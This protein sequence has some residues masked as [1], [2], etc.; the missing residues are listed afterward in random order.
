MQSSLASSPFTALTLK[1]VGLIMIVSSLLDFVILAIPFEPLKRE[2][3]LGFTTQIVDRGIIPMVGIALVVAG[4][5]ISNSIS[6]SG[7]EPK[8]AVQDLRFWVFLLSSLLGLIFLL[9]VPLHI[10]NVSQQSTD[11]QKQIDQKASQ[12]EA[13]LDAQKKNVDLI[14]KD[15]QK[16]SE[17]EKAIGSGQVQGEQLARLQALRE[18]LQ[19]FK[20][21]PKAL[22]QQSEAA[23]SQIRSSKQEAQKRATTE[24]FK[25][26]LR[27]GLSSLLLAIGYA[28][29]GWTGFAGGLGGSSASR[30]KA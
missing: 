10:S 25:L 1:V 21:D 29:I 7:A 11:A 19:K 16:L 23:L 20:Q 17:L 9:L 22:N 2:W 26:S 13:Q 5:W 3:Q 27:T 14:V 15:P 12:A 8:P 24:A 18:Q 6:A 30:R 4:Y 28:V